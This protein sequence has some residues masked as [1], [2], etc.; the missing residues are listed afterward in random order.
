MEIIIGSIRNFNSS[1]FPYDRFTGKDDL[2]PCKS[3]LIWTRKLQIPRRKFFHFNLRDIKNAELGGET[4]CGPSRIKA[5][6]E[7]GGWKGDLYR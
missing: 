4:C 5:T 1:K 7:P 2:V 6:K 3:D